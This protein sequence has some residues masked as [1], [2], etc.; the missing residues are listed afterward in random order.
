MI[1]IRSDDGVNQELLNGNERN[2]LEMSGLLKPFLED[3]SCK[4]K[5]KLHTTVFRVHSQ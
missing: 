4:S 5:Y 2:V 3:S 1:R